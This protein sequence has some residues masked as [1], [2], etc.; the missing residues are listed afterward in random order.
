MEKS[1][2]EHTNHEYTEEKYPVDYR[3]KYSDLGAGIIGAG[4]VF[5]QRIGPSLHFLGVENKVILDPNLNKELLGQRD[6]RIDNLEAIT[7]DHIGFILSPNNRHVSQVIELAGRKVSVYVEKPIAINKEEISELDK[8][9]AETKVPI[10]FADYY[11]FKALGLFAL[12]GVEMPFKEHLRIE[13]D[14]NGKLAD[15]IKTC[16]PILDKIVKVKGYLLEGGQTLPATIE[17]REWLGDLKQGGGMLLD[18][19]VHLTNITNMLDLKI[20]SISSAWLGVNEGIRGKYR[21]IDSGEFETAED[22]AK[23]EG[24]ATNGAEVEFA[25]GKFAK[26]HDRYLLLEDENGYALRLAFTSDNS[27]EWRDANGDFLGKVNLLADPYFLTMT[28]AIEHLTKGNGAMFYEPQRESVLK[29][30]EMQK[31]GRGSK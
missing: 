29:I 30:E 28:H 9:V 14:P 3:N 7:E 10:Y 31:I 19:M 18:L 15:A 20:K 2:I 16:K 17:G 13:H 8:V 25:V 26:E 24:T 27:V 23:V 12:M 11:L 6:Q 1:P 4:Q 21:P 22:F 5:Q